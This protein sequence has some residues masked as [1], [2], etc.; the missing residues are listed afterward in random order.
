MKVFLAI[1]LVSG[2]GRAALALA[3]DELEKTTKQIRQLLRKR[4]KIKKGDKDER[5]WSSSTW[6]LKPERP[7]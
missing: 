5:D 2:I 6:K 1:L 3:K 7:R 4:H